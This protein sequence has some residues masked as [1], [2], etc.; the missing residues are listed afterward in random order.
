MASP[1]SFPATLN[2]RPVDG[3]GLWPLS[4]TAAKPEASLGQGGETLH[5]LGGETLNDSFL[6]SAVI[7]F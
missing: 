4:R 6:T 7:K 1:S 2:A 5:I 3:K